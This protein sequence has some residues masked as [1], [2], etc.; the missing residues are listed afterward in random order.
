MNEL[1]CPEMWTSQIIYAEAHKTF[2][3]TGTQAN[4]LP[5]SRPAGILSFPR[6]NQEA[7]DET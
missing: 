2:L 6:N 5:E 1:S 3:L 7:I 4:G